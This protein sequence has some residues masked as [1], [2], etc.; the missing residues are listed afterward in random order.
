M[1]NK[2]FTLVELLVVIAVMG[3]ITGMAVP[4]IRNVQVNQTNK[5]YDTYLNSLTY[6]AKLYVNSY[7]EDLF[8]H[9]DTGC[10]I[11]FYDDLVKKKLLKDIEIKDVSCRTSETLV[12]VVKFEGQYTYTPQLGCGKVVAGEVGDITIFPE[13]S[14]INTSSCDYDSEIIMNFTTSPENSNTI[15]KRQLNVQVH[16]FSDTGVTPNSQIEYGFSSNQDGSVVNNTWNPLTLQ[17]PN[18]TEQKQKIVNGEGVVV[19]SNVSTPDGITGLYYLV[20]KVTKLQDLV[21]RN[22]AKGDSPYIYLGPFKLDSDKP[23]FN[24]SN[25][26]YNPNSNKIKL[27]LKVTDNYSSASNL[28]MCISFDTDIC[29]SYVK[30]SKNK[31]IK[32]SSSCDGEVHKVYVFVKDKAGNVNM[33]DFEYTAS[34]DCT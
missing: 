30:Y 25:V 23:N 26:E 6:S 11:I 33:R 20:L 19:N 22:F 13:G 32:A 27:K 12:K 1:N 14:S 29:T 16:L 10:A 7:D 24:D 3:I 15:D 9:A 4:L 2:G 8:G 31:S 21:G 34:T 18:T 28:K 17:V 5:K